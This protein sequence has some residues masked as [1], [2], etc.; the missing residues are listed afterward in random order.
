MKTTVLSLAILFSCIFMQAQRTYSG[1]LKAEVI[2][3]PI[4]YSEGLYRFFI[5]S[6][7]QLR[8]GN[9]EEAITILDAA[10]GQ[11]PNFAETYIKRAEQLLRLGRYT[12]ARKDLET[13]Y[14]LNPYATR[15]LKAKGQ[16]EKLNWIEFSPEEYKTFTQAL[17]SE[18]LAK[19]IQNSIDKK[20]DGDLAGALIELELAFLAD[21]DIPAELYNLQG[22]IFLLM[23]D[24]NNAVESYGKAIQLSPDEAYLY[25]NR[26]VAR[27]FTYERSQACKDLETSNRLGYEISKEKLKYFCY[28]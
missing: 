9:I 21:W 7:I 23:E 25:F 1:P 16:M 5:E 6:D 17:D 11:N 26:A 27:L 24:Y 10:I 28:Y 14:R 22:N 8:R 18:E 13:A 2:D 15:F 19:L 20:L 12:E 4:L 3:Q